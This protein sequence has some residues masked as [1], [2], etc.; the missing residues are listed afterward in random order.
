MGFKIGLLRGNIIGEIV[1]LALNP[2]KSAAF[3]TPEFLED[4]DIILSVHSR[5]IIPN[6]VLDQIQCYNVHPYLYAYKG[7]DPVGKAIAE[8]NCMASVGMHKMTEVIDSGELLIEEF[9]Y[10]KLTT[11]EDVYRQLYPLYLSVI[12]KGLELL[13]AKKQRINGR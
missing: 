8:G 9:C 2:V 1:N 10:V 3:V 6:S 13:L 7:A 5:K 12:N 4:I 11:R